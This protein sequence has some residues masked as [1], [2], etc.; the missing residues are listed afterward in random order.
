MLGG[1]LQHAA[2][3]RRRGGLR[4]QGVGVRLYVLGG[5]L[6]DAELMATGAAFV[7][8]PMPPDDYA[9]ACA[10]YRLGALAD[11]S[12]RPAAPRCDAFLALAPLPVARAADPRPSRRDLRLPPG[13]DD[14]LAV[15]LTAWLLPLARRVATA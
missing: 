1:P 3:S 2:Q 7:T 6:N 14:A 5:S 8:G 9:V 10:L 13:D 11:L 12:H 4:A 15:A